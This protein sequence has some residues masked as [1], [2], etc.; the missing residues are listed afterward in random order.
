MKFAVYTVIQTEKQQTKTAKTAEKKLP[1]FASFE[2]S[3]QLITKSFLFKIFKFELMKN[4]PLNLDFK[5]KPQPNPGQR[6][7]MHQN[8]FN[9]FCQPQLNGQEHTN[10]KKKP[11]KSEFDLKEYQKNVQ[12]S[13]HIKDFH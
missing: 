11:S 8:K 3:C 9:S 12:N 7:V 2:S 6:Y 1:S 4:F 13:A 5:Q 10:L